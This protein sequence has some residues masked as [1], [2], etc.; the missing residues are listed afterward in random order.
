MCVRVQ[1]SHLQISIIATSAKCYKNSLNIKVTIA[2]N[3]PIY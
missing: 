2:H 1:V 3:T